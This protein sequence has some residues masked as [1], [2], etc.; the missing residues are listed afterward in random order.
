MN[1]LAKLLYDAADEK[2]GAAESFF[3]LLLESEVY[4]PVQKDS[5]KSAKEVEIGKAHVD[6]LGYLTVDYEGKECLPIFSEEDFLHHWA[7]REIGVTKKDFKSLLWLVGEELWLYIDP[8]Q[9]IGKETV[10]YTHL[11]LPTILL[12]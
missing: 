1:E 4:I 7:K 6:Q 3:E 8:E 12:V 2:A 10:S 11:T 9:E 5:K